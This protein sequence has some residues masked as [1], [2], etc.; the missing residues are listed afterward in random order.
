MGL[1]DGRELAPRDS[2]ADRA[3]RYLAGHTGQS[4]PAPL[5]GCLH[6]RRKQALRRRP[7]PSAAA[8]LPAPR[9]GVDEGTRT[10]NHRNHNPV[11]CR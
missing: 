5:F 4:L 10:P 3:S 9:D 2:P 1:A 6:L 8:A 7:A 11:L